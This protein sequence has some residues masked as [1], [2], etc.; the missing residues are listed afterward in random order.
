[1]KFTNC[2]RGLFKKFSEIIVPN[3]YNPYLYQII[4]LSVGLPTEHHARLSNISA[5]DYHLETISN[6]KDLLKFAG[7]FEISK[8]VNPLATMVSETI[9]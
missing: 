2:M 9:S 7:L 8:T 6:V 4:M 1:M 3:N 5:V